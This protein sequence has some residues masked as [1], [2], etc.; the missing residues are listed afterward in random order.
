[1]KVL[2]V[3]DLQNDY[4]PGGAVP[5]KGSEELVA[6]TNALSPKFEWVV[7]TQNWHPRNHTSFAAAH[8]GRRLGELVES[9]GLQLKLGP[10]H[11][12]Q[13]T[14]G[15]AFPPGLD[16]RRVNDVFRKG[17]DPLVPSH[18][19]FFDAAKRHATGLDRNLKKRNAKDLYFMGVG[20]E[21]TLRASV[22]DALGAGFRA[23]I[24]TDAIRAF[25]PGSEES[26]RVITE[27]RKAGARLVTSA[28]L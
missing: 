4:L 10:V 11:C 5:V 13:G 25:S 12:V 6:L 21:T 27:L 9:D 3:L 14:H 23:F 1:M 19:A 15:A 8:P 22:L 2:V 26:E 24:I 18:S 7:A 17:T 28:S 20:T 16:T